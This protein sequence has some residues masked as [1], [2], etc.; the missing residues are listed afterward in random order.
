M[1]GNYGS[2]C[3]R[4]YRKIPRRWLRWRSASQ[5]APRQ[6]LR[7]SLAHGFHLSCRGDTHGHHEIQSFDEFRKLKNLK[8]RR[9]M[10]VVSNHIGVI[11]A[12]T[13]RVRDM[14][15]FPQSLNATKFGMFQWFKKTDLLLK[16]HARNNKKTQ[17]HATSP[18]T[19]MR[20]T[21]ATPLGPSF[22]FQP[23]LAPLLGEAF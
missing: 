5:R 4:I 15:I 18:S 19:A 1:A 23:S 14:M 13:G 20:A 12:Y 22:R 7:L 10:T 3:H 17:R 8:L 21:H 6:R 2:W 16:S 11:D 9:K